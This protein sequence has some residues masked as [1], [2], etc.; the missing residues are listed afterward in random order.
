MFEPPPPS[1]WSRRRFLAAAV[2]VAGGVGV[3]AESGLG[4]AL[5]LT[6][7]GSS[8]DIRTLPGLVTL[9]AYSDAGRRLGLVTVPRVVKSAAEWRR[10]LPPLSFQV[11]RQAATETPYTGPLNDNYRPGLYRCLG[12]GTALYSSQTKYNPHE[13]WPSFWA[14]LARRNLV[15]R[16]DLSLGMARTEVRCARCDGHLG[17]VFPDGPPPTGLR[18]CMNSAALRFVPLPG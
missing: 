12:C 11:L 6:F 4:S 14:P 7:A 1:P 5:G 8:P 9:A 16:T 10:L 13:G 18:Y 2:G 17:H 15:E 3:L